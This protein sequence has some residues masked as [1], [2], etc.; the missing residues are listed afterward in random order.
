[1][2]ALVGSVAGILFGTII[3]MKASGYRLPATTHIIDGE[4]PV[5]GYGLFSSI[6]SYLLDP[7]HMVGLG[8]VFVVCFYT[9][10][11]WKRRS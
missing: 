3:Y 11:E 5:M 4:V 10:F 9:L 2:L 1:M 8:I 6:Q 7:L